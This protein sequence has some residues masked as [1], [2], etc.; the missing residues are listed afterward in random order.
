MF[1]TMTSLCVATTKPMLLLV[2][3]ELGALS[4]RTRAVLT[5]RVYE[6]RVGQDRY[7]PALRSASERQGDSRC[8]C[9]YWPG[10]EAAPSAV[11]KAASSMIAKAAALV[12]A[13]TA[14]FVL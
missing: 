2:A 1:E 9:T 12:V 6:A 8:L 14:S 11:S 10:R 13:E 3:S 5:L 7:A 4:Q